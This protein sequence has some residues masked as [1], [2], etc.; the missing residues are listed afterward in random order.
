LAERDRLQTE[1][2]AWHK[3]NPGP[4]SA[5]AWCTPAEPAPA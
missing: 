1:M 2:D 3:H 4:I 5:L